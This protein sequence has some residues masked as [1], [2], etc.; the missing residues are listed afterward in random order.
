MEFTEAQYRP[1]EHCL[2]T[3]RGTVRHFD[4][5]ALT[6]ILYV[7][8]RRCHARQALCSARPRVQVATWA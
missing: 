8:E 5:R 7:A 3:Q 6:A 1:I 4:P 2:P